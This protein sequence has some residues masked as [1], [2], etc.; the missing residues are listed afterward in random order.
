M[1]NDGMPLYC[2]AATTSPTP[3]QISR[4]RRG[5]VPKACRSAARGF[6]RPAGE[7]LANAAR[8]GW[9]ARAPSNGRSSA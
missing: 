9:A 5:A 7:L 6:K 2:I 4:T 8:A 3:E 1:H